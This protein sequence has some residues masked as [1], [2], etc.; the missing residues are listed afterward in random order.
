MPGFAPGPAPPR[1]SRFFPVFGQD[2]I[3]IKLIMK[4]GKPGL[5]LYRKEREKEKEE[6]KKIFIDF[7]YGKQSLEVGCFYSGPFFF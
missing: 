4:P 5:Y 1:V 3:N 7:S 2:R 6:K